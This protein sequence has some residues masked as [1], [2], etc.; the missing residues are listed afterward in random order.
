[1]SNDWHFVVW[2]ETDGQVTKKNGRRKRV[3]YGPM[4]PN[5]SRGDVTRWRRCRATLSHLLQRR[6]ARMS[7]LCRATCQAVKQGFGTMPASGTPNACE[8]R[9]ARGLRTSSARWPGHA[10]LRTPTA[11]KVPRASC[12]GAG[13]PGEARPGGLPRG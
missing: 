11:Q 10:E 3:Q 12:G 9:D 7:A 6:G 8:S 13:S 4:P 1:L 5:G 2:P